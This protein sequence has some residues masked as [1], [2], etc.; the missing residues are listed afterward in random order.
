VCVCVCV[1]AQIITF[2]PGIERVQALADIVC[3]APCCHSNESHTPIANVPNSA[4]LEGTPYH[5]LNLH[6]RPCSSVGMWRGTD[7]QMHVTS[8]HF[9][10]ST[11][12]TKCNEMTFRLDIW[13]ADDHDPVMIKVQGQGQ[14]LKNAV[15]WLKSESK[16]VKTSYGKLTWIL[17]CKSVAANQKF[18]FGY[19]HC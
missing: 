5:S 7:R 13:H 8:I 6:P 11:T 10:S 14:S 2:K 19:K 9:A 12:H 3:S 16:V 4:Q 15:D 18:M 1:F 17:N